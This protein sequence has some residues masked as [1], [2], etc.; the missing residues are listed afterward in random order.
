MMP[1]KKSAWLY[2]VFCVFVYVC[3]PTSS[4]LFSVS[5]RKALLL[6]SHR[7]RLVFPLVEGFL[8][9]C[10]L[11]SGAAFSLKIMLRFASNRCIWLT[12]A[13]LACL[14][15]SL[16]FAFSGFAGFWAFL[17]SDFRV[18]SVGFEATSDFLSYLLRFLFALVVGAATPFLMSHPLLGRQRDS[19]AFWPPRLPS[20]G[21]PGERFSALPLVIR[22][23]EL[24][25]LGTLA[26]RTRTH[27]THNA[28]AARR[29]CIPQTALAKEIEKELVPRNVLPSQLGISGE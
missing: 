24:Q 19:R 8:S 11:V 29:C 10:S 12:E 23:W 20:T 16:T 22:G 4:S 3:P 2:D 6:L 27:H 13:R 28:F 9:F 5:V 15:L 18:V 17:C 7:T 21:R 26:A 14:V 25:C 1:F